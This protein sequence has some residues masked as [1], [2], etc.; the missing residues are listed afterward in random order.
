MKPIYEHIIMTKKRANSKKWELAQREYSEELITLEET[1]K[2]RMVVYRWL[3]ANSIEQ[4]RQFNSS[5]QVIVMSP[6]GMS[7][8]IRDLDMRQLL[9]DA[10]SAPICSVTGKVVVIA[11]V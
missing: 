5:H 2:Q 9:I 10:V 4:V 8:P 6:F 1:P 11:H 7:K 3:N